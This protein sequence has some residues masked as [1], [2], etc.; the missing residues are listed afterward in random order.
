[1]RGVALRCMGDFQ[2]AAESY[3]AAVDVC[4]EYEDLPNWAVAQANQG[5]SLD[6]ACRAPTELPLH[7]GGTTLCLTCRHSEG[8][9]FLK[10]GAKSLAQRHLV[11]AVK[12]FAELTE[13]RHEEN[14]IQ[15]LLE[16]GKHYVKQRQLGYGAAC[17]EWA[18]L[19]SIA[20]N[21]LECESV[22]KVAH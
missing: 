13:G 11:E 4:Q 1:M 2:G 17:Y 6:D 21:L 8:L 9:L 22:Q 20:A 19:L 7:S 18:L 16:L 5:T 12:L 14:F 15:V 10:V 3:R